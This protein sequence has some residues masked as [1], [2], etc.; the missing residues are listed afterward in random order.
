MS[1]TEQMSEQKIQ[2][3]ARE[4]YQ[5]VTKHLANKGLVTSSVMVEDS[6]YIA[7]LVAVWKLKLL[8]NKWIWAISGD[9]PCDHVSIEAAQTAK[10]ALRHFSMAW[11]LKAENILKSEPN[12]E[13]KVFAN[14]LISKA[15]G[16]YS[17][18]IDEQLGN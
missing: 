10:E 17:L 3:W 6:R 4:Q 15:E 11:Q 5:G 13:Q 16:L 14:I 7:P 1:N 9:L 18:A 2:L 12:E 8:D